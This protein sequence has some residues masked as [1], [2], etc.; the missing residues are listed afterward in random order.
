VVDLMV[1]SVG[2]C[3]WTGGEEDAVLMDWRMRHCMRC[4]SLWKWSPV[5]DEQGDR[6]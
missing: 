2:C 1:S 5:V 6:I 3:C 4:L